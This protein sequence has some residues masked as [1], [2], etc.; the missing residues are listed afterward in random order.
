VRSGAAPTLAVA[1]AWGTCAT[2]IF[3]WLFDRMSGAL[4][5]AFA[6]AVSRAV[7]SGWTADQINP[8][9]VGLINVLS[10]LLYGLL[11]GFPMGL[12]TRFVFLSWL[13]FVAAFLV[14]MIL[15]MLSSQVE[16]GTVV[17]SL[18]HR[19]YWLTALATLLFAFL[20]NRL[21]SAYERRHAA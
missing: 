18:T 17:E 12:L 16:I 3:W 19:V 14:T 15:R 20:G 2:W 7:L 8:Y 1:A 11:F 9:L 4:I 21:R 6:P 10:A 5:M 13:G